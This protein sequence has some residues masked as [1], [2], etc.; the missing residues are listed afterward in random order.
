M[1]FDVF[2]ELFWLKLLASNLFY[3]QI[4]AVSITIRIVVSFLHWYFFLLVNFRVLLIESSLLGIGL[5]SYDFF[6]R[7]RHLRIINQCLVVAA[8]FISRGG[9]LKVPV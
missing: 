6:L 4:Y 2:N 9:M 7:S 5:Y 8:D 1:C 3:S